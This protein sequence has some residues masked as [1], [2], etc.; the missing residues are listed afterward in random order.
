MSNPLSPNSSSP[1]SLSS[2]ALSLET[3][4]SHSESSDRQSS[5]LTQWIIPLTLAAI[6]LALSY[7]LRYQLM[8]DSHWLDICDANAANPWCAVRARLGMTIHWQVLAWLGLLLAVPAFFIGGSRGRL[9]AW[10]S[11]VFALPALA[12]YTVTPA[13]F[14][15]LIAALR[16]VRLERHSASVSTIATAA[17]PSA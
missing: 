6:W 14:S 3:K 12:L 8:E 7:V 16:I 10:I 13:V 5:L 1:N 11:L 9:L 2:D 15:L 17:Q 4:P